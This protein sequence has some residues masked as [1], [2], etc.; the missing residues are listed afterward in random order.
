MLD[1]V[2]S[3]LKVSAAIYG[4]WRLE[5]RRSVGAFD[6]T[7]FPLALPFL[8]LPS[9]LESHRIPSTTP[10]C[11]PL[12]LSA[13]LGSVSC[14]ALFWLFVSIPIACSNPL[15]W[16]SSL[17]L[18]WR[19]RESAARLWSLKAPPLRSSSST[20]SSQFSYP[21]LL[22][23]AS[24]LILIQQVTIKPSTPAISFRPIHALDLVW[25]RQAQ[26]SAHCA[27]RL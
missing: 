8:P 25:S 2:A 26:S 24:P 20:R 7:I 10:F 17:I 16:L 1:A 27:F 18:N 9:P 4:C 5:D 11:F 3:W 12:F 23:I 6:L 15:R 13:I 21:P 19:S 22:C 14:V